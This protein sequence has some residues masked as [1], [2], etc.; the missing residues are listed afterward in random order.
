[1]K[2]SLFAILL[3]AM[4]AFLLFSPIF[5]A[6]ANT[7]G[8]KNALRSANDYL[9]FMPFSYNG[10]IQQLEYEGYT[11][12]E[13]KYAADSCGADWKE[14]AAIKA[15]SYLEIMA[16][17]REGLMEQLLYEEFTEEEAKYGVGVAY[18]DIETPQF[19]SERKSDNSTSMSKKN[20][21]KSALN[22]LD[23]AAFSYKGLIEQLEY[24]KYS[25]EDAV[26]A[27][28]NCGADWNEQAAKKAEDYLSFMSFSRSGLIEQLE[29]EGF[30]RKQAE[31]GAKS[32]GY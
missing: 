26:Y 15:E 9:R 6:Q 10:L 8:E 2:K 27:A 16:F 19:A 31:Y 1:M 17:S 28:D 22:Y 5:E 30:T 24:E 21:L 25:H 29:Y 4:A 7:T 14:Q 12:R 23:F 13:A 32:S 20:A 11:Q 18:G 3:V